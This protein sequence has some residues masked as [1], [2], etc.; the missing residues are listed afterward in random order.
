M[1]SYIKFDFFATHKKKLLKSIVVNIASIELSDLQRRP[2][3]YI[4]GPS[5]KHIQKTETII[6]GIVW[7]NLCLYWRSLARNYA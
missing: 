5:E 2:D 7:L 1:L 6:V 3:I 4:G